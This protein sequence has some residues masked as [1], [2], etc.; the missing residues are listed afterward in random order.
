M[1]VESGVNPRGIYFTSIFDPVWDSAFQLGNRL[2]ISCAVTQTLMLI[3]QCM[4]YE[5]IA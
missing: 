3:D 5:P 4:A 1:A 2:D